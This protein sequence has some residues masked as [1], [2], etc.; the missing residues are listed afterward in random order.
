MLPIDDV[1]AHLMTLTANNVIE[2]YKKISPRFKH[3]LSNF[4]GIN[5]EEFALFIMEELALLLQK[6]VS[7]YL[8]VT[9]LN[10][11]S[12]DCFFYFEVFNTTCSL[13][14]KYLH[15]SE[16]YINTYR[17][18]SYFSVEQGDI[19][20]KYIESLKKITIKFNNLVNYRL[21]SKELYTIKFLTSIASENQHG[22]RQGYSSTQIF[23]SNQETNIFIDLSYLEKLRSFDGKNCIKTNSGFLSDG[24]YDRLLMDC[25]HNEYNKSYGCLPFFHQ[26]YYIDPTRDV[27]K[28]SL[29][30]Y[31][32]KRFNNRS[33]D[34]NEKYLI[35]EKITQIDCKITTF[36]VEKQSIFINSST[37]VNIIPKQSHKMDFIETMKMSE[38]DLFYNL[39]GI[40]GIWIGWSVVSFSSFFILSKNI[41]NELYSLIKRQIK[42]LPRKF[43]LIIDICASSLLS[44]IGMASNI[45]QCI[46]NSTFT[47]AIKLTR[48]QIWD[49]HY[50][51][52]CKCLML[53]LIFFLKFLKLFSKITLKYTLLFFIKISNALEICLIQIVYICDLFD[54]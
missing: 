32:D 11:F 16:D 22:N 13:K 42:N 35:C 46:Q 38:N 14:L 12:A 44:L 20:S 24:Y 50:K 10:D 28:Y 25:I 21:E 45:I 2:R 34:L 43:N 29:C 18:A 26:D 51:N 47:I 30:F 52:V 48:L 4:T 7:D 19:N 54:I 9:Q 3:S 31:K 37:I 17:I 8:Y 40:V 1:M 6:N 49:F 27:P 53:S 39:G 23:Y 5:D 36:K 15:H 33:Y 41:L